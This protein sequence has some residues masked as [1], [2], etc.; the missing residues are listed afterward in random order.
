MTR[1]QSNDAVSPG[2]MKLKRECFQTHMMKLRGMNEADGE[3]SSLCLELGPVNLK[4]RTRDWILNI[5]CLG[6]ELISAPSAS[7]TRR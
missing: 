4:D 6:V 3:V 1:E 7:I 5:G 2:E